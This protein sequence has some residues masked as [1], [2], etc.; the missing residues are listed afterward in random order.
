MRELMLAVK[1]WHFW[2]LCPLVVVLA[3]VCWMMG[4]GAMQKQVEKNRNEITGLY[5]TLTGIR[6]IQLHPNS[7]VATGMDAMIAERREEVA[8]AWT[9][10]YLQQTAEGTGILSWPEELGPALLNKLKGLHPIEQKVPFPIRPEQ[11][12][13]LSFRQTYQEHIAKEIAK[14]AKR[15]GAKWYVDGKST[16]GM[17]FQ[18]DAGP[19]RGDRPPRESM[20]GPGVFGRDGTALSEQTMVEW[21]AESQQQVMAEHFPWGQSGTS[22]ISS[23]SE[24][25]FQPMTSQEPYPNLLEILYAQEDLWVLQAIMDVIAETNKGAT[26]R[27]DA[28]IKE[29]DFIRM[30][31]AA[32]GSAGHVD[33]LQPAAAAAEVSPF[34]MEGDLAGG[35]VPTMDSYMM[36]GRE[37]REGGFQDGMQDGDVGPME[38][39]VPDPA[40]GRYVDDQYQPLS[41]EKLRQVMAE[42]ESV[43]PAEAYLAVAKRIPVRLRVKIDQTKLDRFLVEL[44]NSPLTI[45]VRQLRINPTDSGDSSII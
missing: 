30:G 12:L 4:V 31:K 28:V 19:R 42:P 33:R 25:Q 43:D 37:G 17:M 8:K 29:I 18:G 10:K 22:T 3:G 5:T 20:M 34:G 45:E 21:T 40:E 36:G 15:I 11:R 41:A 6:G 14:L 16:P 44:A 2:V 9:E 38:M 27:F 13:A 32:V 39:G 7:N 23:M 1:K 24:R 35:G 26:A